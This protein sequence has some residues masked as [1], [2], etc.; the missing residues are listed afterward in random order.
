VTV[1][2]GLNFQSDCGIALKLLLE[3][4]D[5]LSHGVDEELILADDEVW[6]NQA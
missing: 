4:P 1:R 2:K 3:Y 5:A 6:S